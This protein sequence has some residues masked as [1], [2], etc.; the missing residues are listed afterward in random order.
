MS[1]YEKL[2]AVLASLEQ[3][4]R[5]VR[6]STL[7]TETAVRLEILLEDALTDL[8]QAMGISVWP[9][10]TVEQPDWETL[11]EWL[12][13]SVCEATDGCIVEHDGRC[14]HGHPAWILRL[15]LI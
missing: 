11:E 14:P 7:S 4:Q 8:R 13:D 15:G 9:E 12:L 3:A 1:D 10:P 5:L 2:P 6:T